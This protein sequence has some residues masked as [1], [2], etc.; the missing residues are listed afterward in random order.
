MEASIDTEAQS[1]DYFGPDGFQE[2]RGFPVKVESNKLSHNME[3]AG[4]LWEV[5]E[6]LT[7]IKFKIN[8]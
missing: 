8:S 4:K 5:S 1:G 6:E 7:G 2:W 3:I